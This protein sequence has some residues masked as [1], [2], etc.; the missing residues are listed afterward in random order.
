VTPSM[1]PDRVSRSRH[2]LEII[3]I[4]ID[5]PIILPIDKKRRLVPPQS[6]QKILIVIKRPIVK[7]DRDLSLILTVPDDAHRGTF[8]KVWRGRGCCEGGDGEEGDDG[9]ESGG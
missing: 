4:I 2:R 8:D 6:P 5:T 7:G 3:R 1:T 9:E